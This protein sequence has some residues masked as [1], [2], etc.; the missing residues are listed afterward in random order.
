MA[1][2]P[3]YT[4]I[5]IQPG[6]EDEQRFAILRIWSDNEK[7]EALYSRKRGPIELLRWDSGYISAGHKLARFHYKD[8]KAYVDFENEQVEN[9]VNDD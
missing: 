8:A 1:R 3:S 7:I 9:G 5:A 4:M 2:T 6:S